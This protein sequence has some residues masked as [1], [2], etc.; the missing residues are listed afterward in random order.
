MGQDVG[1][2][3]PEPAYSLYS[4]SKK[5]A[6]Q[7]LPASAFPRDASRPGLCPGGAAGLA[8]HLLRTPTWCWGW[9]RGNQGWPFLWSPLL[10]HWMLGRASP[11]GSPSTSLLSRAPRILQWA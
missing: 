2:V 6:P 1:A 3:P 7:L 10:E 8:S 11:V 5:K 9:E 4:P